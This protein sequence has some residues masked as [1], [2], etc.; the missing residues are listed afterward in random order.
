MADNLNW[1]EDDFKNLEEFM[2]RRGT[3]VKRVV[4]EGAA[5]EAAAAAWAEAWEAWKAWTDTIL[6][7]TIFDHDAA[8]EEL[9]YVDIDRLD[10]IS[11]EEALRIHSAV[12]ER[13]KARVRAR[14]RARV[15]VRFRARVR[16]RDRV[17]EPFG[18]V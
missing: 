18:H 17:A 6:P 3:P 2:K 11:P 15:R 5:V 12:R 8:G 10:G 13:R 9:D 14:D 1:I 4:K 7:I 16:V